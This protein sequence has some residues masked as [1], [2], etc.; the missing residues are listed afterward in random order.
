MQNYRSKHFLVFF[1]RY[2]NACRQCSTLDKKDHVNMQMAETWHVDKTV[3]DKV[4]HHCVCSGTAPKHH[5]EVQCKFNCSSGLQGHYIAP[6]QRGQDHVC[7]NTVVNTD[8]LK[9]SDKSELTVEHGAR[10]AIACRTSRSGKVYGKT[11]L[12]Q[13][14][15]MANGQLRRMSMTAGSILEQ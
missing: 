2:G 15:Q 3:C 9:G 7:A 11:S 12:S 8:C 14:P 10:D 13:T 6:S 4:A 1:L 5:Q